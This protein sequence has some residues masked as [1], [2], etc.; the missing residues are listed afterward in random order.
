M[1]EPTTGHAALVRALLA[2]AGTTVN[3]VNDAHLAALS[4]EDRGQIVS[5]D[6]DFARFDGVRWSTPARR[7]TDA[8]VARFRRLRIAATATPPPE[9][10][11]ID[12]TGSHRPR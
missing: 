7:A 3:L 12:R 5:Y 4:I 10:R 9:H 6:S 2:D 11:V 8:V 1:V